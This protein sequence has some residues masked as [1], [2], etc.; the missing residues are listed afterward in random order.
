MKAILLAFTLASP[1]ILSPLV[2]TAAKAKAVKAAA[3]GKAKAPAKA[4]EPPMASAKEIDKF[5]GDFKWGMGFEDVL[6]HV[7]DRIRKSYDERL[8]KT[9]NDPSRQDRIRKEMR[10]ELDG[11]KNKIIKFDGQKTGYDT[12]IIDQEF[13]HRTTES[14]VVF[15]EDNWDRYFFFR[16]EKLYKMFIAFDKAMF[17]GKSFP[18]FGQLMQAKFGKAK[19]VTVQEKTKAGVKVKLDHYVWGSKT[20]DMLRLVDRSEFY[21][22]FCLVVYEGRVASDLESARKIANPTY[23]K[24]DAL[25][26]AV[27]SGAVNDRD[28]NDN[29]LDRITGTETKKV[30]E[31]NGGNIVVPSVAGARGPSPAEV[32]RREA[33]EEP[34]KAKTKE[35][36][37]AN[38]NRPAETRGL[39]L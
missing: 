2:A 23:E 35:K 15:K 24:R 29:I 16:D 33:P 21:D 9:A 8:E 13:A 12:S 34:A 27:T 18:E 25:V 11:V 32:N 10:A 22:V 20:G 7:R 5:K 30:G 38:S 1:F 28:P 26:E 31:G 14:M 4:T 17:A 3:K 39:E 6:T 36:D 19:E 37:K